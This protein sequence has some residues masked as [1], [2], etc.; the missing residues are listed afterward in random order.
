MLPESLGRRTVE[1]FLSRFERIGSIQFFGGEPFLNYRVIK[2]L[3]AY[4]SEMCAERGTEPPLFT[5]ITNGT[6]LNDAILDMVNEFRMCVTVSLD[7][8]EDFNDAQ[9]IYADGSGSFTKIIENVK[10]LKEYTGQPFQVEG[11]FTAAHLHEQFSLSQFMQFLAGELD[12]HFLH[13]PWILGTGYNET[14]IVVSEPNIAAVVE[15]YKAAITTSLK[16]L[17]DPDIGKTCL[18]SLVER[19]LGNHLS[20]T[21]QRP[22][23]YCPAGSGTL[24]V[25]IDGTI[26][27]CF[28]FTNKK[29]FE[30][31]RVGATDATTLE[32]KRDAFTQA[33][34]I[35]NEHDREN[36]AIASSCAGI[37]YETR[38]HIDG[39]SEAEQFVLKSLNLY[40]KDEIDRLSED[41]D[42][43][44]WVQTKYLLHRLSLQGVN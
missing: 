43:W 14:G 16:S 18:I 8:L 6:V 15:T 33:L 12:V 27:P 21:P 41:A 22:T 40:L 3:C 17:C 19:F 24:S 20:D 38:G 11:T 35:S 23:H 32:Q 31:G 34:K 36:V 39:T 28:M 37:N 5:V 7:G 42:A 44:E 9:R 10:V 4:V 26:Y 2:I 1:E 13:M 29:S 25:G 30:I